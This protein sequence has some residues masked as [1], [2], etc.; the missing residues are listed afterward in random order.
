MPKDEIIRPFEAQIVLQ[1]P[2]GAAATAARR[3]LPASIVMV[4]G[5]VGNWGA[6]R[7]MLTRRAL[8]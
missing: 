8:A 1:A 3:A 4:E 2:G 6:L 7:M 5:R